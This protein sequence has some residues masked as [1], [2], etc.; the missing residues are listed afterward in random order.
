[1]TSKNPQPA[2]VR[3]PW[4]LK[5]AL[6]F[7]AF[8]LIVFA[9]LGVLSFA[10]GYPY[11]NGKEEWQEERICTVDSATKHTSTGGFRMGGSSQKIII[12]SPD[13]G[14]IFLHGVLQEK[15][16][17]EAVRYLTIEETVS[18]LEEH[19][20]EQFR[21]YFGKIQLRPL[22]SDALLAERIELQ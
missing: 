18:Y 10:V 2:R 19:R 6:S 11:I 17:G 16:I 13:C 4:D 12:E 20:G 22:N 14:K 3:K 9:V 1:M 15:T 5:S 8:L 7:I 21:F